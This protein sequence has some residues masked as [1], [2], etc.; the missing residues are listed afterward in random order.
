M[1]RYCPMS[2]NIVMGYTARYRK[3]ANFL[4][5]KG[6]KKIINIQSLD[7]LDLCVGY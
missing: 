5:S 3:E 7:T 1:S 2:L 4:L 6:V